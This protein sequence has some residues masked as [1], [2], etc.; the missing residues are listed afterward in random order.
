MD[1]ILQYWKMKRTS[2]FGL[3]LIKVVTQDTI[4]EIQMAHRNDILRLRVHL[5]RIR[6]LSYMI[7]RREKMKRSWLTCHRQIVQLA[8]TLATDVHKKSTNGNGRSLF[9]PHVPDELLG[10]ARNVI[11]SNVIY[12]EETEADK[13]RSKRV[14][15]ELNRLAKI[16][17]L[18][19]RSPNPYQRKYMNG[20]LKRRT[21]GRP[22]Q[23]DD[24]DDEHHFS[25]HKI[26]LKTSATRI[27]HSKV[28]GSSL[29]IRSPKKTP[30]SPAKTSPSSTENLNSL[31]RKSPIKS[32]NTKHRDPQSL[33]QPVTTRSSDVK[34][35]R[36]SSSSP[37]KVL[38]AATKSAAVIRMKEEDEDE[39]CAD[40]P[41][42]RQPACCLN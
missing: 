36:H 14:I 2:N 24:D 29:L 40:D 7:C 38:K 16:D 13:V 10:L 19:K 18:R 42:D 23:D 39:E 33:L 27:N 41:H 15:K 31:L 26:P 20:Q 6:N 25:D 9:K 28:N 17:Q 3:P 22:D 34:R 37:K 35:K 5:E 8:L 12:K 1:I 21:D 11:S 32:H 30:L 4:E